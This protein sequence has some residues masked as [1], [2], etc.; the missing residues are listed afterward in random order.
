MR[1][2]GS[3][4]V[5][6]RGWY[7]QSGKLGLWVRDKRRLGGKMTLCGSYDGDY[8]STG[9]RVNIHNNNQHSLRM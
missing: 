3:R 1:G 8:S 9:Y 6:N 7:I 5:E 4:S 2:G